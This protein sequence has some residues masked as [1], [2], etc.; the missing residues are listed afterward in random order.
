MAGPD[1]NRVGPDENIAGAQPLINS[2]SNF[3]SAAAVAV[4]GRRGGA[5]EAI[6]PPNAKVSPPNNPHK[7]N[8]ASYIKR[9]SYM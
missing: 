1:E 5:W 7:M 6:A 2:R 8:E 3:T 9:L 4:L